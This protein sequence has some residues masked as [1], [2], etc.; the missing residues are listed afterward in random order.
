MRSD[1]L[2]WMREQPW[3]DPGASIAD[4]YPAAIENLLQPRQAR[5]DFFRKLLQTDVRPSPG[6]ER[7]VEFRPTAAPIRVPHPLA[8][9]RG[10]DG[11][12]GLRPFGVKPWA[13]SSSCW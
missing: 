8:A 5:A 11:S 12:L 3:F 13:V 9:F 10:G 2:P 4:N 7:L 1:W 6:Y